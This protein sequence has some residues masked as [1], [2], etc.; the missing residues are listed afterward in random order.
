MANTSK[1]AVPSSIVSR[2]RPRPVARATV[3]KKKARDLVLENLV[4]VRDAKDAVLAA[5]NGTEA[6]GKASELWA[7]LVRESSN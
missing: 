2:P 7:T 6:Q 4:A 3:D 5:A 1:S